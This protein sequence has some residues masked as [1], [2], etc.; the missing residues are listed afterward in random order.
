[1]RNRIYEYAREDTP[2]GEQTTRI[3]ASFRGLTQTCRAIRKEYR[4]AYMAH[5]VFFMRLL[6]TYAF[7]ARYVTPHGE[8]ASANMVINFDLSLTNIETNILPLLQLLERLPNV[9]ARVSYHVPTIQHDLNTLLNPS[10]GGWFDGMPASVARITFK[11]LGPGHIAMIWYIKS[12]DTKSQFFLARDALRP[13]C[14]RWH[15]TVYERLFEEKDMTIHGLAEVI[16]FRP[17]WS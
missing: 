2:V 3:Q 1:L 13:A 17:V 6:D 7:I 16:Q 15:H 10:A 11:K 4:P 14:Q 8:A 9:R 12:G 5:T